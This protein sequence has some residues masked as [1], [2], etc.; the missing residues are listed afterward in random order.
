MTIL[1]RRT[2]LI[3]FV[4]GFLAIFVS[5]VL[6]LIGSNTAFGFGQEVSKAGEGIQTVTK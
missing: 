2:V 5:A 3:L 6:A 4:S 1:L